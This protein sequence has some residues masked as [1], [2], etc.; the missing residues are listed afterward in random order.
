MRDV[1]SSNTANAKINLCVLF[2]TLS[3]PPRCS[4]KVGC[5][6]ADEPQ[7]FAS[8]QR[9]C[10]ELSVQPKNI[11]VTMSEVQ[12]RV[13][14]VSDTVCVPRGKSDRVGMFRYVSSQVLVSSKTF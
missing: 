7:R 4:R 14:Y 5:E 9:Q 3:S 8:D 10:V 6:R 2:L 13:S 12:V 11:S 1:S